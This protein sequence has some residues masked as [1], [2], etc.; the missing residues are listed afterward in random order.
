MSGFNLPDDVTTLPG[1]SAEDYAYDR[2]REAVAQE[3]DAEFPDDVCEEC[4][5]CED[6]ARYTKGTCVE[7]D[8]EVL[9]RLM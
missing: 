8:A 1:D 9:R 6:R 2:V 7:F 3:W 4:G 5:E